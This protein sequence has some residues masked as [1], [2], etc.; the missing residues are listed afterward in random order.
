MLY[1]GKVHNINGIFDIINGNRYKQTILIQLIFYS[2]FKDQ[3]W[4]RSD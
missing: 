4:E 1:P 2:H 3:D